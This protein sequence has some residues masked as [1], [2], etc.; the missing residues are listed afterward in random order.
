MYVFNHN[1]DLLQT[2]LTGSN[3]FYLVMFAMNSSG[4]RL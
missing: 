4:S 1:R 3:G 2:F